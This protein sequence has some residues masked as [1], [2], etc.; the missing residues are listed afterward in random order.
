M[1]IASALLGLALLSAAGCA[2]EGRPSLKVT[3]LRC[4]LDVDPL[5]VDVPQ[6]RLGWILQSAERSQLQ[7]AYQVLAAST[8]ELLARDKSD[9]WD[10]GKV[11]SD[12]TLGVVYAGRPLSSS[13]QV[14]WKVRVW[15]R[16]G[17]PSPWS[18]VA[19]WT[20]GVL[21]PGVWSARWIT[22]PELF[23]WQRPLLGYHSEETTDADTR[24]WVQLDLGARQPIE[25]VR[26]HALRHTVIEALGFPHRFK[27]E[28]SDDPAFREST[29]VADYG[30]KDYP[31]PWAVH[32][33][34]PAQGVTGRY[35]RL[36]APRLRVEEGR[37]CLALSQIEV[38]SGGRNI[39]V[40]AAV[41]ASDSWERPPWS[42]SAL[43][44]GLGMPGANP[45]ANATLLL[46]REFTVRPG[47]RRALVNVCGLGQY[48]LMLN[49][50]RAGDGLLSPGWTD[51]EKTCLYDT[52]DVT[53]LLRPGA[54]AV[55]LCLAGGMYNVQ[56]GRFV[57]FVSAER[58][59]TAIGRSRR[60]RSPS[61]TC[62]AART[63]TR[64]ASRAA[65]R[66]PV[67]TIPNGAA[68]PRPPGRRESCAGTPMRRRPSAR[69][70]PCVPSPRTCSGPASRFMISGRT[71]R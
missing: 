27:L 57:K 37:A 22:D 9:L 2:F 58:P 13:Q 19:T 1:K 29:T 31:N 3:D 18:P 26:L 24:K 59:L 35:V 39:A 23:R 66:N 40:G 45:R 55:G 56:E 54:N 4:E 21:D 65:G 36:T 12:A 51:Y 71:P 48:E 52:L 69:T 28:V 10:S 5:G 25:A 70:R 11:M 30:D 43:T 68:P 46:R 63:M 14:F 53:A 62:T 15:H 8:P 16:R 6:P 34:L 32:I 64:A 50:V 60:A 47:L 44:D 41:T 17:H 33:E 7:T 20:M 49:G 67:S 38:I 42:A 61:R